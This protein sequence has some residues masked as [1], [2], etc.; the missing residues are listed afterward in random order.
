[1]RLLART[2]AP[3]ALAGAFALAPAAAA[4]AAAAPSSL[5]NRGWEMVSPVE[6]NGGDIQRPGGVFGG[7]VW[8]AAADGSSVT[9]SSSFSFA[10]GEGAPGASQYLSTRAPSGWSTANV[11]TPTLAGAYGTEPDG[12][13]YQLF[14]GDLS[15]GLVFDPQRCDTA[16]CPR[17]Y[18]LRQSSSGALT[19][20]SEAPD[21][22]FAGASPDLAHV[23]LSTCAALTLDATEAPGAGVACDPG[24]PNLYQ[25]SGGELTLINLLPGATHGTPGAALAVQAGAISSDGTRTYFTV[26]GNLYLRDG[27]RTLQVDEGVGG[28]GALQTASADGGTALFTKGGHLYRYLLA[29]ETATDLTPPGGVTGVL[30]TSADDSFVYYLTA[31]GLFLWHSGT[32]VKVAAGAD[33]SDYPPA[34]GTAR[35]GADG[36][37]LLFLSTESLTG[38]DNTDQR[39]GLPDSEVFLYEA[40]GAGQLRCVSCRANGNQPIGPSTIPG[41]VANGVLPAAT[42]A[43]KPR[44]LSTTGSRVFFD[45]RDAVVVTDSNNDEDVYEWEADGAGSCQR[46]AGCLGLVSSGRAEE[47]A[48]FLDASS[49]GSDAFFVTD[50]SLVPGD[51]GAADVYDARVDGGFPAPAASIPCVGDNCQV[52]PGEPEDPA[53]G[54]AFLRPEGNPPVTF[55]KAGAKKKHRKKKHGKHGKRHRQAHHKRAG[56]ERRRQS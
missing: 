8:Q 23:V 56:G 11:T 21:L 5:D 45:S 50:D 42:R 36:T 6:K 24:E 2:I 35:V 17:R 27:A 13:P 44:V 19:P 52:L 32:T 47:G 37:R 15:R 41:T 9:Y 18:E 55:P 29:G 51:P 48:S 43:Y 10:G 49:D 39:T 22:S 4:Q 31:G 3:L 38:Y 53:T 26:A 28:G 30:G 46:V 34:T 1:V 25:W 40:G 33:A 14:S 20:S 7:G 12:V 16:P 54:T